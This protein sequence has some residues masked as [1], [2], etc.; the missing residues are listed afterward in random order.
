MWKRIAAARRWRR[1]LAASRL[2]PRRL[3][4][5]VEEPGPRDF[6]LAGCPRTGTSLLTAMLHQPPSIVTVMEPWDGLKMP[7][8]ELFSSLRGEIENTGELTRGR[9]DL[10]AL[11]EGTVEW[12]QDGERAYRIEVA[13]T[14]ELGVKWPTFWQYLELLPTT[15][16]LITLR[17]PVEVISSFRRVGGRLEQGLDYDVVFN[18]PMNRELIAASDDIAV[19]RALLYQYINSRLLPHLDKDNVFVV[20]YERWF[21][22][23]DR[24][25]QEISQFL[26]VPFAESNVAI[27]E[28]R[29]RQEAD[30]VIDLV[31]EY[32]PVRVDLGYDV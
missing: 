1:I 26:E 23:P 28:E 14:F 30:D 11:R 16:F 27:R 15:R 17:D 12:Q 5:P 22:D 8:A 9:L 19:R 10:D 32:V 6:I 20:R 7:P 18:E 31:R 21:S 24:L 3:Q 13:E 25:R 29:R 4:R 2:D